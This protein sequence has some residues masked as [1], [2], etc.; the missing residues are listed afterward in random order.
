MARI[1]VREVLLVLSLAV[2]S[3]NW[4]LDHQ[5]QVA[6]WSESEQ[7]L[8]AIKAAHGKVVQSAETSTSL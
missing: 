7:E 6:K 8:R 2:V 5:A 3:T 1:S 4:W